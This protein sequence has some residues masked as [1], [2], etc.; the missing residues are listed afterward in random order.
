MLTQCIGIDMSKL[1]EGQTFYNNVTIHI[2][3]QG[4]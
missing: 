4:L 3:L 1:L 2:I